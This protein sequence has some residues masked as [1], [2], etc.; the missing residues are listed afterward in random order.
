[1]KR[2]N[3]LFLL[4][5]D[6]MYN[7]IHALGNED[8]ITP[9]FDALAKE[10]TSFVNA[11]LPGGYTGAICMPSRAMINTGKYLTSIKNDGASLDGA[12][13]TLGECLKENGYYA[14]GCGKWHNGPDAF[15]RSFSSGENAFFSGMW[16]HWNVPVCHYDKEGKYDNVV[17][18]IVNFTHSNKLRKVHCDKINPGVHSSTLIADTTIEFINSYKEEKPFFCYS[19]F[20]APHDPRTMPEEFKELY[21]DKKIK[22]PKNFE[23]EYPVQYPKNS[24]RDEVLTSYPRKDD[25]IINEIKDYYA[26]IT[27]LDF[28]IGRI[29]KALK[30]KGIYNDTLII[31][32]SDNGL[33]IGSHAFLGKQNLYEEAIKVPLIMK[34]PKIEQNRKVTNRLFLYDIYPTL[35][36]YLSIEIPG[37][38]EGQSFYSALT[39]E[40]TEERDNMYF[41]ALDRARAIIQG[42]YKYSLYYNEQNGK[43]EAV[44]Y[45]LKEDPYEMNNLVTI[46]KDKAKALLSALLEMRD[47]VKDTETAEAQN[48]W[49]SICYDKT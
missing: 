5:D 47:K 20:L 8:I 9:N 42:D 17:N 35:C 40:T 44:L 10:G 48:F 24:I 46:E 34:G 49:R 41:I 22:L 15:T 31:L 39:S 2:P 43:F 29:V 3:I 19:A 14:F 12:F 33:S 38:V 21:R 37:S 16:D 6:Q 26:M 30:D 27:H 25:E 36:E 11:Y 45:N 23:A 28:E 32:V 1:M 7:T 18:F 13:T 4:T